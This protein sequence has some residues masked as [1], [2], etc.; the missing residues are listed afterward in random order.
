MKN[1]NIFK[2]DTVAAGV[3]FLAIQHKE[4]KKK[5]RTKERKKKKPKQPSSFYT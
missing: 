2:S 1:K 5:E 3:Q 4:S